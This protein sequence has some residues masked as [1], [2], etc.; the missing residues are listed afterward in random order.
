MG[1]GSAAFRW[2]GCSEAK[3]LAIAGQGLA[4]A[5]APPRVT[6]S[7]HK[8]CQLADVLHNLSWQMR[9]WLGCQHSKEQQ[10]PPLKAR[11]LDDSTLIINEEAPQFCGIGACR[12]SRQSGF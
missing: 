1:D 3:V 6:K 8:L 2:W 4:L 5:A 9:A 7:Q 12:D 11:L 10:P